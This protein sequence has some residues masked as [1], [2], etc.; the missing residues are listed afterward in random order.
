MTMLCGV[1]YRRPMHQ[2]I[3][4]Q[5]AEVDCLELTAEHFFDGQGEEQLEAIVGTLPLFVH[6]L[7]LSL[8]TPGPLDPATLKQFKAVVDRCD[9]RWVSEHVAFTRTN[10]VDLG[11]LNPVSLTQRNIQRI[12]EKSRQLA[13]YCGKPVLLE[14]ITSS[15]RF[16]GNFSETEFLNKICEEGECR[17]LLD[18]TNLYIN[19]QNH[20]FD[21]LEWLHG[22]DPRNIAQLHIVGYLQRGGKWIDS[23]SKPIQQELWDLFAEVIRYSNVE[24]AIIERDA[25]F[26]TARQEM[27]R[28]L[29]A[30]RKFVVD[31]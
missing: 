7:G 22:I 11:H 23:H 3:S 5:P 24:A 21:P 17:L 19:S 13:N 25:R 4:S 10:E 9:P 15:L 2:W 29:K 1:G 6:G 28:D 26:D 18:V 27:V 20:N 8:G 12:G 30:M 16:G 14:N 31:G